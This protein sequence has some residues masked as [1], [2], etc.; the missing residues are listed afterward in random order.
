MNWLDVDGEGY[1]A[2]PRIVA[3]G[4]AKAAPMQRLVGQ[5]PLSHI[6]VLTG[7]R[8][9]RT[10]IVLDS[11]HVVITSLSMADLFEDDGLPVSVTSLNRT[12]TG[13]NGR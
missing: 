7:G 6:V 1:V 13:R 3:V 4:W 11:G 2:V 5:T 8:R 10:I 9:R 12:P